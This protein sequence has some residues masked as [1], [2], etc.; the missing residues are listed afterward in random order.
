M[1]CKAAVI[2]SSMS[3]REYGTRCVLMLSIAGMDSRLLIGDQAA[4]GW[5]ETG[6]RQEIQLQVAGR[7]LLARVGGLCSYTPDTGTMG[8]DIHDNVLRVW[9]Q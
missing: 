4:A 9:R 8:Q 6:Y 2:T 1:R 3:L 7:S 5:A